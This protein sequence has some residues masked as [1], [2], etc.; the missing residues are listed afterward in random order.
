MPFVLQ[1]L[2]SLPATDV[3][4][5]RLKLLRAEFPEDQLP[6]GCQVADL[7]CA[8]NVKEKVEINGEGNHSRGSEF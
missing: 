5:V 6:Q 3:A 4:V 8:I 2:P 7:S 1:S